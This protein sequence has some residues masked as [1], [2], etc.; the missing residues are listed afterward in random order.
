MAE[1]PRGASSAASQRVRWGG[2]QVAVVLHHLLRRVLL[3]LEES[4]VKLW[5]NKAGELDDG[6]EGEGV[7]ENDGSDLLLRARQVERHQGEPVDRVDA[8]GEEDE[9]GL[10]ESVRA[11]A[12]LEGVEGGKEDEEEGEEEAGH[13]AALLNS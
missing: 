12:G 2:G 10:V 1:A 11:L 6:G 9:P 4:G 13:E 8:V 7:G 3:R 5:E